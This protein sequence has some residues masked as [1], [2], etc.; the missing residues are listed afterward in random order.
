MG[1][2]DVYDETYR[3][4]GKLDR[5]DFALV[6]F[7][8]DAVGLLDEVRNELLIEGLAQSARILA[9]LYKL[10]VYGTS[11]SRIRLSYPGR[12]HNNTCPPVGC[13]FDLRN[14]LPL[15]TVQVPDLSSR[16]M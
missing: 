3:K 5:T 15:H 1:D 2:Q 7:S 10:N 14:S 9:E 4:A 11:P 13:D 8:P 6:D 12:E 16:R